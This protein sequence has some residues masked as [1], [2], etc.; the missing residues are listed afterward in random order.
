VYLLN[1]A[2]GYDEPDTTVVVEWLHQSSF[3]LYDEID[4]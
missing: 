3:Y 2:V 4:K 1:W